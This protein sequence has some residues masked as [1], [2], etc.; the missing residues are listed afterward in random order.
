MKINKNFDAKS[1]FSSRGM[2]FAL[3][4]LVSII[5]VHSDIV[6]S[7]DVPD[8]YLEELNILNLPNEIHQVVFVEYNATESFIFVL[9]NNNFYLFHSGDSGMSYFSIPNE[10]S[11]MKIKNII[12]PSNSRYPST[13]VLHAHENGSDSIYLL[14]Y[15]STDCSLKLK[16]DLDSTNGEIDNI[17]LLEQQSKFRLFYARG[18]NLYSS[19]FD[20]NKGESLFDVITRESGKIEDLYLKQVV[21]D[22]ELIISGCFFYKNENQLFQPKL[23][24]YK[25][26]IFSVKNINIV[27]S[28]LKIKPFISISQE[29]TEIIITDGSE[30][31]KVSSNAKGIS[32]EKIYSSENTLKI[33]EPRNYFPNTLLIYEKSKN[34]NKLVILHDFNEQHFDMGTEEITD[35]IPAVDVLGYPSIHMFYNTDSNK[36]PSELRIN[37]ETFEFYINQLS[38]KDLFPEVTNINMFFQYFS[39]DSPVVVILEEDGQSKII[40][41]Y[42]YNMQLKSY[43][44]TGNYI[45]AGGISIIEEFGFQKHFFSI[46]QNDLFHTFDLNGGYKLEHNSLPSIVYSGYL[47]HCYLIDQNIYKYIEAK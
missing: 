44:L 45:L 43:D 31:Y 46:K 35:F 25:N 20:F 8:R 41:M 32:S 15:S 29:N 11:S 33:I 12:V 4:M 37:P 47:F 26:S 39:H 42:K 2:V 36:N 23:F 5:T 10:I 21:I 34:M 9:S 28:N 38:N 14:D 40:F 22:D 16:L 6:N 1:L 27:I 18:G 3:L 13:I 24:F 30:I 19:F 17:V 7:S